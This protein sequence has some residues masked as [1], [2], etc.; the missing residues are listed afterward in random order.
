MS[1]VNRNTGTFDRTEKVWAGV[2]G[3]DANLI[4]GVTGL[5]ARAI[6][7]ASGGIL[8]VTEA[9]GLARTYTAADIIA[10][11]GFLRGN[12]EGVTAAGSTAFNLTVGW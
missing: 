6:L 11:Q 9:G 1:Y 8:V 3:A 5:C 4:D 2:V 12:F 10:A 7:V